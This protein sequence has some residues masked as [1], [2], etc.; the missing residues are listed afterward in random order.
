M[1]NIEQISGFNRM[2][3]TYGDGVYLLAWYFVNGEYIS[4]WFSTKGSFD[5]CLGSYQGTNNLI[6]YTNNF[7]ISIKFYSLFYELDSTGKKVVCLVDKIKYQSK[8]YR[9]WSRI[10]FDNAKPFDFQD[11]L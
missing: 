6:E 8:T 5:H 2:K 4:E 11:H 7:G 9:G 1:S 3:E 10:D